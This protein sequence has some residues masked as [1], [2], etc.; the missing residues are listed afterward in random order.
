MGSVDLVFDPEKGL[1]SV[2]VVL[3]YGSKQK[4]IEMYVD[5]AASVSMIAL[6]DALDLGIQ[7]ERLHLRPTGGVTRIKYLRTVERGTVNIFLGPEKVISP[8]MRVSEPI[9]EEKRQRKG[10]LGQTRTRS[11]S[12]INLIGL[13][14]V[15]AC[16][17]R[18]LI[19]AS[20]E[21]DTGKLEWDKT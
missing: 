1:F 20:K 14:A 10:P 9:K 5:T 11:S 17:A 4:T 21:P 12:A 13:D 6:D 16:R 18:I 19:D 15:R 2:G 8:E 7:V 3:S